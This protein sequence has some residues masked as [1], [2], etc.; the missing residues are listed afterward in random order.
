MVVVQ[1]F[2]SCRIA[3][4]IGIVNLNHAA[5]RDAVNVVIAVVDEP[6]VGRDGFRLPDTASTDACLRNVFEDLDAFQLDGLA[7]IVR[8]LE[9]IP[10]PGSGNAVPAIGWK[11]L[12][13]DLAA[14][15]RLTG[16]APVGGKADA[17][18]VLAQ[19]Q[20]FVAVDKIYCFFFLFHQ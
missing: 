15:Q 19:V 16:K 20:V 12:L 6:N 18:T 2:E 1:S 13:G 17:C 10:V 11:I 4:A 3:A 9:E 7:L 5:V 8:K 14:F